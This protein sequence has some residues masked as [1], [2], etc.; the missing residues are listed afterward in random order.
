MSTLEND[1]IREASFEDFCDL[2][3]SSRSFKELVQELFTSQEQWVEKEYGRM[4]EDALGRVHN[5]LWDNDAEL[6]CSNKRA[7]VEAYI[8]FKSSLN[9]LS[10]LLAK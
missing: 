3:D 2:F 5:A 7:A 9:D 8:L 6:L 10:R 1:R 4:D